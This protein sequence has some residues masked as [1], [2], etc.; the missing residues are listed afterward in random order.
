MIEIKPIYDIKHLSGLYGCPQ[1][2]LPAGAAAVEAR[3]GSE[4][5]GYCLFSLQSGKITITDIYPRD[6]LGLT[7]GI[8]RTALYIASVRGIK[9]AFYSNPELTHI[10]NTLNFI[11]NKA[12]NRLN[13]SKLTEGC[14]GC[15]NN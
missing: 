5:L 10:F 6:D 8:L 4:Q 9:D 15:K 13:I 11:E 1:D 7:D 2:K 3:E 14:C 12:E